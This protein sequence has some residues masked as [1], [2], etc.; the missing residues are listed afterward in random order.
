MRLPAG[1]K[2]LMRWEQDAAVQQHRLQYSSPQ[3]IGGFAEVAGLLPQGIDTALRALVQADASPAVFSLQA[4]KCYSS[5][6]VACHLV[7]YAETPLQHGP[8]IHSEPFVGLR[9]WMLALWGS[10]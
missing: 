5:A 3:P 4:S 8:S 6:F 1:S 9:R 2:G 10:L 7:M